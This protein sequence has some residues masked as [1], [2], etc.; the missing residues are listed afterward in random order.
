MEKTLK[1]QRSLAVETH[2]GIQL[3]KSPWPLTIMKGEWYS[4]PTV[5]LTKQHYLER[6]RESEAVHGW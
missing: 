1:P 4:I 5:R 3:L 6:G 2:F